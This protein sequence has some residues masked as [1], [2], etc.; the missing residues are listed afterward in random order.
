MTLSIIPGPGYDV[1][2]CLLYLKFYIEGLQNWE[3]KTS[4]FEPQLRHFLQRTWADSRTPVNVLMRILESKHRNLLFCIWTKQENSLEGHQQRRD[5]RT[6][7]TNLAWGTGRNPLWPTGDLRIGGFQT[8]PPGLSNSPPFLLHDGLRGSHLQGIL[9][10][11]SC[12]MFLGVPMTS[13]QNNVTRGRNTFS[14]LPR[15]AWVS[16]TLYPETPLRHRKAVGHVT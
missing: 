4:G 2:V 8:V 7:S 6:Q 5:A 9:N 13:H 14:S 11:G 3:S 10:L 12:A 16:V 1:T 15:Q